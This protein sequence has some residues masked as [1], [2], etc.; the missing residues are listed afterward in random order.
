MLCACWGRA[1]E[2]SGL[3]E[4]LGPGAGPQARKL[5][6]RYSRSPEGGG[7]GTGLSQIVERA[8]VI[9]VG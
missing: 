2:V 5:T 6:L 9:C 3:A 7:H 4:F 1:A 8:F